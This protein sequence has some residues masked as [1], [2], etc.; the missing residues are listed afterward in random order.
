MIKRYLLNLVIV[1]ILMPFPLMAQMKPRLAIMPFDANIVSETDADTITSL[2]E[3]GMVNTNTY[4]VIEQ[5][6]VDKVLEAQKF[7]LS[8]I[9]DEKYA[10]EIGKLLSAEQIII[11]KLARVGNRYVITVKVIDVERGINLRAESVESESMDLMPQKAKLLAYKLAGLTI[12]LNGGEEQIASSFGEIFIS[13]EP[14]D[15]EVFVNGMSRGKSPLVI[16]RVPSG[17]VIV[18]AKKDRYYRSMEVEV[19]KGETEKVQMNLEISVG[20]IFIKSEE[21]GHYLLIDGEPISFGMGFIEDIPVGPH[22][23]EIIQQG[24]EEVPAAYSRSEIIIEKNKTITIEPTL[25]PVGAFS[26]VLPEKCRGEIKGPYGNVTFI[27]G[28]AGYKYA[29]IGEYTLKVWGDIYVDYEDTFIV[30]RGEFVSFEPDLDYTR[31][32]LDVKYTQE[33]ENYENKL[34]R[35]VDRELIENIIDLKK[36]VEHSQYDF[37]DLSKQVEELLSTAKANLD[38]KLLSIRAKD[39]QNEIEDL[40]LERT[41]LLVKKK[42][43]NRRGIFSYVISSI[44]FGSMG[45]NLYLS[46]E[47]YKNYEGTTLTSEAEDSWDRVK[48]YDA[49]SIA[50]GGIGLVGVAAGIYFTMT[51]PDISPIDREI[52]SLN[53]NLANLRSDIA[54]AK[55][56][57]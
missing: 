34:S 52:T 6:E 23:I 28:E 54:G 35:D 22:V 19:S 25:D 41:R 7:S 37:N 56:R 29:P 32:Y 26:V 8:G 3:T 45:V 42:K 50:G 27:K 33:Y 40:E 4:S 2:F 55:L 49:F 17:S 48:M 12:Q 11:G 20:N 39:L 24:T 21:G 31:G 57:D 16:D 47:E 13:T 44:G 53:A 36:V 30:H 10:V 38:F 14:G 1:L 43:G 18:E 46:N 5:R 15:A 9:T 51:K